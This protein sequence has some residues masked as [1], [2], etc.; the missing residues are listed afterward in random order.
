[1]IALASSDRLAVVDIRSVIRENSSVNFP[2]SDEWNRS[3][4]AGGAGLATK[5]GSLVT[6]KPRENMLNLEDSVRGE[7][8]A[9][10]MR[11][12]RETD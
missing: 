11:L 4:D 6:L 1:M 9:D 5:T 2:R 10:A 8:T 3:R 12:S 7:S